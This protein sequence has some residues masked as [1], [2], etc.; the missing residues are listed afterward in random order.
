MLEENLEEKEREERLTDTERL[1]EKLGVLRGTGTV[2]VSNSLPLVRR[3]LPAE[4]L[5][6]EEDGQVIRHNRHGRTKGA[7]ELSDDQREL[8]GTLANIL[9]ARHVAETLGLSDY[10]V[11]QAKNGRVSQYSGVDEELQTKLDKN[12]GRA[13]DKALDVLLESLDLMDTGKL[14]KEDARSLSTIAANVSRVVEKTLPK[15][16]DGTT[17]A[18]LIVYAPTQN[19]ENRFE[20][21]ELN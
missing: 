12:L 20:I 5:S 7:K 13:R 11:H 10:A 9:P 17:R 15:E 8:A 21:V 18:Q 6:E 1:L 4:V 3:E 16:R 14:E 19:N 2:S